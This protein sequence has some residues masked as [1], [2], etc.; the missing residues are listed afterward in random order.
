MPTAIIAGLPL[1]SDRRVQSSLRQEDVLPSAWHVVWIRSKGR[2]PGLAPS[3]LDNLKQTAA[4]HS[5]GAQLLVFRGE[6]KR[7]HELLKAEIA[8][9]FRL[10]W[11]DQSIL[12]VDTSSDARF[13][14]SYQ[15]SSE[16]GTQMDRDGEAAG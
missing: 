13:F 9:Y 7:D 10:R 1:E 5:G 4:S 3:Q 16:R 15:R 6:L 11:L 2:L 14:R 12:K 8:P